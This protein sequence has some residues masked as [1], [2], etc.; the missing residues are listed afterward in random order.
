ML[1]LASNG[2]PLLDCAWGI[3][4]SESSP[5][6]GESLRM[7]R[8][9]TLHWK[10]HALLKD[11]RI[12]IYIYMPVRLSFGSHWRRKPWDDERQRLRRARDS[13]RRGVERE[14]ENRGKGETRDATLTALA[15]ALTFQTWPVCVPSG[16]VF[17]LNMNYTLSLDLCTITIPP[18]IFSIVPQHKCI[19]T[20]Y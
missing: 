19:C 2:G 16:P 9:F 5:K 15:V 17:L 8:I 20:Q 10:R 18:A 11:A 3:S 7:L 1:C 6:L 4:C 13:A 12:C 14:D